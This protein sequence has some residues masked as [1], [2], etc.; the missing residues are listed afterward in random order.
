MKRPEYKSEEKCW[1]HVSHLFSDRTA[2]SFLQVN[3]GWRCSVHCHL[4]RWNEFRVISGAIRI[5]RYE[6]VQGLLQVQTSIVLRA[7][8]NL[9]V[10]PGIYHSFE[11]V[12]SG[13]VIETYWTKD[14]TDVDIN[15]IVRE[16]EGGP[17]P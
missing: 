12:A 1:G 6:R 14:G 17:I 10:G 11:V 7:D 5:I 8:S 3:E 13:E 9:A 4:H 15:D 16:N 2:L